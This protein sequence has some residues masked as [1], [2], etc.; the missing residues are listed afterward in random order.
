M[1]ISEETRSAEPEGPATGSKDSK[2][3]LVNLSCALSAVGSTSVV[4]IAK[5]GVCS[6]RQ[7]RGCQLMCATSD[8][9]GVPLRKQ[10]VYPIQDV[11]LH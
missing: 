8:R 2:W 9:T 11:R 4:S 7:L 10:D 1:D 3:W 5:F 6:E